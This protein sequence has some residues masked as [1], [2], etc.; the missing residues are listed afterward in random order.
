MTGQDAARFALELA[1]LARAF[2]EQVDDTRADVYFDGLI[3][4]ELED[5]VEAMTRIRNTAR[6]FPP[7][8][9]IRE[10][11]RSIARSRAPVWTPPW[12]KQLPPG[13]PS[14]RVD[15]SP[16]PEGMPPAEWT[17]L[18]ELARVHNRSFRDQ[19]EWLRKNRIKVDPTLPPDPEREAREEER[20]AL[21]KRQAAEYLRQEKGDGQ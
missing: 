15:N 19:R 5:V 11:S 14:L 2:G 13:A 18:Q 16:P 7:I 3:T 9:D 12:K 1:K 4:F 6:K 20:R 10:A 17:S 8:V 21:L